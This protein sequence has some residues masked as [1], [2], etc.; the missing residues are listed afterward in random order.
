VTLVCA[1]NVLLLVWRSEEPVRA[2]P[3]Q[4]A[5]AERAVFRGV[6]GADP[7][8]RLGGSQAGTVGAVWPVGALA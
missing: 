8:V 7:Y 1:G 4:Q 5:E 3:A 2:L 6:H